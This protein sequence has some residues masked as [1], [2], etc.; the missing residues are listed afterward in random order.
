MFQLARYVESAAFFNQSGCQGAIVH[1]HICDTNP[2]GH[3]TSN[4]DHGLFGRSKT[5]LVLL[6]SMVVSIL[7]FIDP[8]PPTKR[9]I[10]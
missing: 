2:H 7:L 10:D 6:L 8:I 3:P 1:P 5:L 4:D 9:P